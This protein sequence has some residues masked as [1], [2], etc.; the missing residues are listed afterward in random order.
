MGLL[1]RLRRGTL[2]RRLIVPEVREGCTTQ[3]IGRVLPGA[4]TPLP[5]VKYYLVCGSHEKQLLGYGAALGR[6]ARQAS[7]SR[8]HLEDVQGALGLLVLEGALDYVI[9][10]G[11]DL[12]VLPVAL[13]AAYP[14][15]AQFAELLDLHAKAGG[16][17]ILLLLDAD[18]PGREGTAHVTR[19]LRERQVPFHSLPPLSR[20][21]LPSVTYKDLG[22]L[23]PL[24]PAGRVH[25][26]AAIERALTQAAHGG[27]GGSGGLP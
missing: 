10:V 26:L 16:L 20:L 12:P 14:S 8:R 13:L 9:A 6:L 2:A 11:W 18:G 5:H 21:P 25:L 24:G 17:P 22:E 15:R 23:G 1:N 19:A 3:L 7:Q 27:T 4:R